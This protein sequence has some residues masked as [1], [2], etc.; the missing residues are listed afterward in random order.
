MAENDLQANLTKLL[1]DPEALARIMGV[2]STLM[3][4]MQSKENGAFEESPPKGQNQ[5]QSTE[6]EKASEPSFPLDLSILPTLL[7]AAAPSSSSDPRCTLL[8]ALKPYM[9]HGRDDKIEKL[10]KALKMSELASGFLKN[11]GMPK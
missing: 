2:A 7:G 11:G 4:N 10:I 8:A 3:G 5:V 1:E 6:P 9:G